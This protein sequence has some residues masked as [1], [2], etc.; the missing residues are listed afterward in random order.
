MRVRIVLAEGESIGQAF[1]RF[2]KLLERQGVA[3]D[4]RRRKYFVK[5]AQTRRAKRFRKRFKAR[6]ATLLAKRAG[7][8][9]V[10]SLAEAMQTFWKRTGKP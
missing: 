6:L 9:P 1:R 5:P 10:S 8:Q 3:W 7:E 4:M 2:R